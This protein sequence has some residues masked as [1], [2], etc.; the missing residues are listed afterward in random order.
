MPNDAAARRGGESDI[1]A[2]RQAQED[3]TVRT[4]NTLPNTQ[5]R[6]DFRG[7]KKHEETEGTGSKAAVIKP[8]GSL[9]LGGL[10]LEL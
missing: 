3:R 9:L 6:G 7:E 4:H 5:I 10:L 2:R 8:P 1:L